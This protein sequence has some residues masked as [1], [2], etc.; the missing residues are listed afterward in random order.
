MRRYFW[1][2]LLNF[3]N[4][5]N[6]AMICGLISSW[7]GIYKKQKVILLLFLGFFKS[8]PTNINPPPASPDPMT[9][10]VGI[11]QTLATQYDW[12]DSGYV[13]PVKDQG[14]CGAGTAFA[15][16]AQYESLLA[17][18]SKGQKILDL[19]QQYVF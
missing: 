1:G 7:T 17:I 3:A 18:K 14:D 6:K 5:G 10:A 9:A 16:T 2:T 15:T 4:F 12:R 11:S 8:K 19:A 13:T